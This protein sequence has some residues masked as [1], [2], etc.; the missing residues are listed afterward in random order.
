MQRLMDATRIG[1]RLDAVVVREGDVRRIAV[2]PD[3]LPS[4]VG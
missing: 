1:R 3:E 4:S 2:V